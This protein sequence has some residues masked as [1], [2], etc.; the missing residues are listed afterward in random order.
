MQRLLFVSLAFVGFS[1]AAQSTPAPGGEEQKVFDAANRTLSEQSF[2]RACDQF[3]AFLKQFPASE[4]ANEA[5]VKRARACLA[6]GRDYQRS[7]DDLRAAANREVT[8]LPRALANLTL[9]ERGDNYSP[10]DSRRRDVMALDQ[11]RS[12]ARTAGGRWASEARG[13]FFRIALTQLDQSLYDRQRAETLCDQVLGMEPSVNDRGRALLGRARAWINTGDS[14]YLKRAEG[15]LVEIGAG[16]SEFADDALFQLGQL[17]ATR[18]EFPSALAAYDEIVRRFDGTTSNVRDQARYAA[19]EIRRPQLSSSIS[20]IELP[21]EKPEVSITSRNLEQLRVTLK[22]TDP[23]RSSAEELLGKATDCAD[24]GRGDDLRSWTITPKP[25]KPYAYWS[26][27]SR[28]DVPGPGAYVLIVDAGKQRSCAGLLVTPHALALKTSREGALAYVADAMTGV[29]VKNAKVVFAAQEYNPTSYRKYEATT[30]E[31]GIARIKFDSEH[32]SNMVVAWSESDGTYTYARG[33][34]NG[35]YDPNRE[36]LAYV[37][38]DRPLYKP[39]EKLGAKIFVRSREQ[40]PSVPAA[41]RPIT[42]IVYDPQGRELKRMELT[43]SSFGTAAFDLPL[44]KDAT[45]GQYRIFVQSQ[46]WSLQQRHNTFRVED[47]KPPEFTVKVEPVGAP[48]PGEPVKVRISASRFSG[49][50]VA[51]A[52]GRAIVTER[53]YV[54]QWSAWE[55]DLQLNAWYGSYG[56]AYDDELP[57]RYRGW[58][59]TYKQQTLTFKTGADGTAELELP[60]VDGDRSLALQVFLTDATRRE[61]TGAGTVNVS[62]TQYFVD[63]RADRLIYKPGEKVN[64]KL[65]S[66]DANGRATSPEL[67]VRLLRIQADGAASV[68]LKRNARLSSGRGEVALDGDAVGQVRVEVKKAG[69][70]DADPV[71]ASTDLWMTNDAKPLI[72][73]N[74]GFALYT[75]RAPLKAGGTVRALLV[76]PTS[77]GHALITMEGEKLTYAATVAMNGRAKFIEIPLTSEM[78]P[79]NWLHVLRFEQ[80]NAYMQQGAVRVQGGDTVLDVKVTHSAEVVEPGAPQKVRVDYVSKGFSGPAELALTSVDESIFSIEEQALDFVSWFGRRAQQQYVATS[81]TQAQRAFRPPADRG[82]DK[83]V[84]AVVQEAPFESKQKGRVADA[85]APPAPKDMPQGQAV[86]GDMDDAAPMKK[87]ASKVTSRAEAGAEKPGAGEDE[88][89]PVKVRTNFSSSAGWFPSLRANGAS[90]VSLNVPDSLTRFRTV[91]WVVTAGVHL[92]M[93]QGEF[94][95]EKPLMVRLEAPRFFTERDEVTLSA[96]VSNRLGKPAAITVS[97]TAPGLKPLDRT[98]RTVDVPANGDV[99]VD[100]RY[101]VI[102]PGTINV[103]VVAKG[104]GKSDAMAMPLPAVVH[105]SAQRVSFSG[106]L[107]DSVSMKVKMP[108]LRNASG[109]KLQLTVSPTVLSVMVDALPYLADYPYGCVE[110][111]LSRFVPATVAARAAREMR[112]PGGRIPAELPQMVDSGLKRLYGFQHGDGGWGWWQSDATNRW[113]SA[114]VVYGLSLAQSA[115]AQVDASVLA[116]GRSYLVSH[117]GAALDNPE[118]HAFMVF[119]LSMSGGAPKPALDKA[120]QRRTKL[121]RR[122]RGMLALALIQQ[123]DSRAR[124][125]VENLDDILTAA[126]ERAEKS[127]GDANDSWS[128]SEAIEATAYALM[129]MARYDLSSPHVRTLTDFL[130]LRRNGGKWRT[131]RDTAFAVY[132][133]SE[134]ARAEK[135]A[136][137]SGSLIVEVNGNVV[138]RVKYS[139]GGLTMSAPVILGDSAFK[140]GENVITLKRDGGNATGYYA[141]TFDVYNRDENVKGVGDDIKVVRRY[142]LLGKPSSEKASAPTEYGMPVE[143]GVRVRVDLEFKVNKAMQFLMVEDLKP[144]GFEAVAQKSGPELCGYRCA[145]AELRT[146][147]VAFFFTDVAVGTTKVSYELRAEVP[148]RF[149]ALPARVEAM[150]APELQATSDEMRFEVRDA[151]EAIET[152]V[153]TDVQ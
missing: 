52:S 122:G 51:N 34:V 87:A 37:V 39:G 22:K 23:R 99:R 14:A 137:S 57:Y 32:R 81:Y 11:L 80:A 73:P 70:T 86:R 9:S 94:R 68:I 19:E 47:Y 77:G 135:A 66:E 60:K 112:L 105:G 3:S 7:I 2:T 145:H 152:G 142:T 63:L 31:G 120:F 90:E 97:F 56:Y 116:R 98:Q 72:P 5:K 29:A 42:A 93:A 15:E 131:T 76:T 21:G 46:G 75:D 149:H 134:V 65:R 139:E 38:T 143:S 130:V 40:G 104:G 115:G 136:N 125:A 110:Q 30:D 150:Y 74:A 121:S 55:D 69:A 124:I 82:R 96:L 18:Q 106:R 147:R 88:A 129:A 138:G 33:Y 92:G 109:T 91:A 101:L 144:A 127:V 102:E 25:E 78:T 58:Q 153:A 1:A 141:T 44:A 100:A 26:T 123:K 108:E 6:Q 53:G 36:Y 43:T 67:E 148:G 24:F 107:N 59:P 119:A 4:L 8:D 45:L 128:T 41:S 10:R 89:A 64:V 83:Q 79:N 84:Q 20:Y 35:Y 54:H 71:L 12:V 151:P 95:T 126:K 27:T 48:K 85:L 117:L 50:P 28:I 113:M 62:A 146:D 140:P 103:Q 132:A 118:E 133:L 16:K 13:Y 111:T 114:Y 61:V 49:G 17:R